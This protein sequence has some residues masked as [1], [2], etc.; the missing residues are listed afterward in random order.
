MAVEYL[1]PAILAHHAEL[2]F[3]ADQLIVLAMRSVLDTDP[4]LICPVF[5][6]TTRSA[7]VVSSVS[8][9]RWDTTAVNPAL[10]AISIAWM[11]SVSVPI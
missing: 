7:M 9:E 6:A 10:F 1:F 8:P 4:V 5:M 2:L 3:D 11:V